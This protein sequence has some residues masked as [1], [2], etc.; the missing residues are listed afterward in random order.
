LNIE[1]PTLN[2]EVGEE[3]VSGQ[4]GRGRRGIGYLLLGKRWAGRPLSLKHRRAA[5]AP[6]LKR[7]L[8]LKL[9]FRFEFRIYDLGFV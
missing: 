3:E 5:R 9:F 6:L 7:R 4:R 1:H 8:L 2:I